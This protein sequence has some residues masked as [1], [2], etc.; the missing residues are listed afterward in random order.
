MALS[1]SDISYSTPGISAVEPPL[2][3]PELAVSGW[4][5]P[6]A[7]FVPVLFNYFPMIYPEM[8]TGGPE[9]WDERTIEWD[10]ELFGAAQMVPRPQ[11]PFPFYP[12]PPIFGSIPS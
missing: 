10:R 12:A 8:P 5:T 3:D 1:P 7:P 4:G 6:G 2:F 11:N 9:F